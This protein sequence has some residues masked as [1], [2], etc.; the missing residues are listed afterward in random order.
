[1]KILHWEFSNLFERYYDHCSK[2]FYKE[3]NWIYTEVLPEPYTTYQGAYSPNNGDIYLNKSMS[4]D[5]AEIVAAHELT[6]A[7]KHY[8][9]PATVT[10]IEHP[11]LSHVASKLQSSLQDVDVFRTLSSFGFDISNEIELR[12]NEAKS[13]FFIY[14]TPEYFPIL[15]ISFVEYYYYFKDSIHWND[16][17]TAFKN[18][19]E[20]YSYGQELLK[21]TEGV[22]SDP[23]E[24]EGVYNSWVSVFE[25]DDL[26]KI[27]MPSEY[28]P[29][30]LK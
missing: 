21:Y 11:V 2:L 20:A 22:N 28:N 18:N 7:S 16:I 29:E 4:L 30:A 24:V 12:A 8:L 9:H 1:M 19:P 27:V 15:P 13:I 6:H 5:Q 17:E 26:V 10:S 3:P 23:F 14:R 25:M